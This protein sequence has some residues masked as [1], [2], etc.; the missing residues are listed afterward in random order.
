MSYT[1]TTRRTKKGLASDLYVRWKG[2]RYRPL[3]G[4]DLSKEEA[5]RRAIEMI[6]K[7]HRGE[8]AAPT[9]NACP[10]LRQFLPTYWQTMQVKQRVDVRRPK[11]ILD[12][13]LLPR[14]GDRPLDALT[15]EDGLA[16]ITARQRAGAAPGTIRREWQVLMRILNLAVDF[17]KLD[18][19]RLKRVQVPD[20]TKRE[21]VATKEELRAIQ[22]VAQPE[23]WRI[24][25]VALHTGLRESKILEIERS[26]VKLRDDGW[27]LMLPPAR[28]ALK[29]TP[30]E[31]PLNQH[32]LLALKTQIPTVDGPIFRRWNGPALTV[33]WGR[34]C[35]RAKV[36]D[37]HFHDLRHTF[38]TRLQNLGV[39][40]E[41][42][43]ALLGHRLRGTAGDALGSE[44]MT[45]RY[46]HGGHGWN[47]QLRY[48]V[49]LLE[50]PDLSYGLSYGRADE[51][52]T[53]QSKVA[54][55]RKDQQKVW[56]SQRDSNPCLGLERAPS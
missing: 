18:R 5:H 22:K 50:S 4:H 39:P 43:S 24:A 23:L 3:L 20:T 16:Y 27:W 14:F 8:L 46:S 33:A 12:T 35:K 54:N 9:T 37:L 19:N 45:V 40:L 17:E 38:A 25:Q 11:N 10:T 51:D 7:I 28:T 36:Q 1:I 30:R 41:I 13:H 44:S 6:A 26:W 31:V 52:A 2:Q 53:P 48:A 15:P 34:L 21:R 56:W 49:T 47:Q 32:A 42:R 29:D 55:A